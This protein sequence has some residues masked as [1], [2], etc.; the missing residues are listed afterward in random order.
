MIHCRAT[1]STNKMIHLSYFI[2]VIILLSFTSCHKEESKYILK[3]TGNRLLFPIDN[4][5]KNSPKT[6]FVYADKG[7]K[8]YLTFQNPNRNEILF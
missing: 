3:E 7:N 8:Q 2:I 4:Q 1:D 6:L 5:T